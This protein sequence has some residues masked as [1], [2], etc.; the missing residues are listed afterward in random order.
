VLFFLQNYYKTMKFIDI[1]SA[2]IFMMIK[3]KRK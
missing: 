2:K 1:N 3:T